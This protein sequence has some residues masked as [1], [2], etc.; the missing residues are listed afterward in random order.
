MSVTLPRRLRVGCQFDYQS[1]VSVPL[2]ML[3]RARRDGAHRALHESRWVSPETPVGEYADAYGNRCWRLVVPPGRISLRYDAVVEVDGEPDPIE[4]DA[5]LTPVEQLP[6]ETL[7]YTLPSRFVESD[8]LMD[9]A[10][11]LFGN[12]PRTWACVQAICDW[13]HEN[14]SY[15]A[16]SSGPSTTAREVYEARAGV[17]RDLALISVAFCRAMNIPARYAFGYLPDIDVEPPDVPMDFHAWFEAYVG[18]RWYTFDARHNQPRVGRVLV[19]RG[20]DAV[21]VALST[22]YGA[23]RLEQ[24]TVWADEVPA[25]DQT[26]LAEPDADALEAAAHAGAEGGQGAGRTTVVAGAGQF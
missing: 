21:D 1:E 10:W 23:A 8:L 4:P 12:T 16:G 15:Q 17:C 26:P 24:M 2:L 7:V 3:V 20:R 18:G 11:K 25:D 14:I 19:G 13:V 5:A 22:A 9:P 6:D